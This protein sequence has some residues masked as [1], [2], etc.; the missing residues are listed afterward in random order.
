MWTV[1]VM[2]LTRKVKILFEL[3]ILIM[4]LNDSYFLLRYLYLKKIIFLIFVLF[5]RRS[6]LLMK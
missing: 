4:I 6:S 2:S 5:V 1:R 3:D